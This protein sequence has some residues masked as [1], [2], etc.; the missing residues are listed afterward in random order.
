[1][2][3]SILKLIVSGLVLTLTPRSCE[4]P[5]DQWLMFMMG[6]DFLYSITLILTIKTIMN[7]NYNTNREDSENNDYEDEEEQENPTDSVFGISEEAEKNNR[8][9]SALNAICK[10]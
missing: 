4:K 7:M 5:I 6:H 10:T 2:I 9:V 8:M 3:I 1:M